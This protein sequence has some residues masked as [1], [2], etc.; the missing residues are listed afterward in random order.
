VSDLSRVDAELALED[1]PRKALLS[2]ARMWEQSQYRRLRE[3]LADEGQEA[4]EEALQAIGAEETERK[5]QRFRDRLEGDP[6]PLPKR[7][8]P[9]FSV[10]WD[11]D[12]Y[13]IHVA[14]GD[15]NQVEVVHDNV[16][17]KFDAADRL[18]EVRVTRPDP[19]RGEGTRPA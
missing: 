15:V 3:I 4:L 8:R 16:S 11:D 18:V 17:L 5:A 2:M 14:D 6:E 19:T 7:R 9:G 1:L 10:R 12:C 13:V